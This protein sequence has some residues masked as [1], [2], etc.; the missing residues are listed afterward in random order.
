MTERPEL[1]F[2]DR[3]AAGRVLAR[4]L[5]HLSDR[6]DVTVLGLP[7]GGVP[8]AAV[9]ATAL[10]APLDVFTVR[11]L[12]VPGHRELAM[13]AIATGGVGV[14]N[15]DLLRSLG[16]REGDVARVERDER[17]EL[18][19]RE[20]R[21][22]RGRAPLSVA[23]QVVV[24]VDDGIATGSTMEAALTALRQH[25]PSRLV[26]ATP[27][28]S[29]DAARRLASVA[30]EVVCAA[31]PEPFRAVGVWYQH[32][33]QTTDDEVEELLAAAAERSGGR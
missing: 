11:K 28:A 15:E 27:V 29:T 23:G 9:V 3:A 5:A 33:D 17:A 20:A 4:D 31:T 1:P 2:T 16:L 24:V 8:V 32:F 13:G 18:D 7:R 21:Y 19:R 14:L 22:R 30:D 6:S 25:Q 10:D 12:G 26:L